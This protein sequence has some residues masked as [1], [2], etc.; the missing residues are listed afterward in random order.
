MDRSLALIQRLQDSYAHQTG[1]SIILLDVE[2]NMPTRPS[3]TSSFARQVKDEIDQP[4]EWLRKITEVSVFDFYPGLKEI[5]IPISF[6]G[7][8]R[9][10]LCAGVIIENSSRQ[11][12][13]WYLEQDSKDRS[14][15]KVEL[16]RLPD[17]SAADR[18]QLIDQLMVLSDT[19]SA[20]LESDDSVKRGKRALAGIQ[21]ISKM[22]F[23]DHGFDA[24]LQ[25]YLSMCKELNFVG[26]ARRANGECIVTHMLGEPSYQSLIGSR[27]AIGEGFIGLA[28][29]TGMEGCWNRVRQDPRKVL[30]R[31]ANPSPE[32]LVCYPVLDDDGVTGVLFGGTFRINAQ[33]DTLTVDKG[34][35]A[36]NL[37][38]NYLNR[39]ELNGSMFKQLRRMNALMEI[40]KLVICTQDIKKIAFMLVDMSLNIVQGKFAAVTL[41]EHEASPGEVRIVSRGLTAEQSD[42]Y[43][44]LVMR[45]YLSDNN[46]CEPK[47]R[48]LERG[49][50]V[51]ECPIMN[52]QSLYG[53]LSIA[54]EKEDRES[55]TFIASMAAI[56]AIAIQQ[57]HQ[58]R[59]GTRE[60]VK[61]LRDAIL[62]WN[63]EAYDFAQSL[64]ERVL[65]FAEYAEL[66]A[67]DR[68]ALEY[69]SMLA[70]YHPDIVRAVLSREPGICQTVYDYYRLDHVEKSAAAEDH[71][72]Y[73]RNGQ[74]LK[75]ASDSLKEL[76]WTDIPDWISE[77]LD[78]ELAQMF[79][80]Y[81]L[82]TQVVE[83]KVSTHDPIP[84][85]EGLSKREQ[86]VLGY[87]VK[88]L[89]NKQI[90]AVMFISE[91]TVKNHISNV[92]QKTGVSDRAGLMARFYR[93]H[94]NS[95]E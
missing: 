37:L 30:F 91:H 94:R 49:M 77:D 90:A 3:W 59:E 19:I 80:S 31:H 43:G 63:P 58:R 76:E 10:H 57:T 41:I 86:E 51:Q 9:Y 18:Q 83:L 56:G 64:R 72:G 26:F 48:Q 29:A 1:L 33:M 65:G 88:G 66:P 2:G 92:Y 17:T 67:V 16:E 35:I 39:Q 23:D 55:Q 85:M 53:V 45:E 68:E 52:H 34:R 82:R 25:E 22:V 70:P 60:Q 61:S 74:I 71:Q 44:K 36:S 28:M 12:L 75:L 69:A 84:N 79:H 87:V 46:R 47:V 32:A 40:S 78:Q 4:E 27:F 38:R 11:S 42:R 20:L 6:Q 14:G 50:K 21:R 24:I 95:T 15:W 8:I 89:T 62:H 73:C 54:L 7:S 93:Q 5:I 13:Y 81:M